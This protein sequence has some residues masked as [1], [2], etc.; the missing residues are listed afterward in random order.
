MVMEMLKCDIY[1]EREHHEVATAGQQRSNMRFDSLVKMADK[2]MLFKY[3]SRTS[4]AGTARPL[5]HAEAAFRRQRSGM[6]CHQSI[7]NKGK[8]LFAGNGYA[9]LRRAGALLHRRRAEACACPGCLYEPTTNSYKR[10]TPGFEAP[11][12]LAYSARNR[13]ASIRIPT[14]SQVRRRK[15]WRS[16]SLTLPATPISHSLQC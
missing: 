16:G 12:N 13:S 5:L 10:L 9:G 3:S 2:N 15:G 6:H 7:W 14:Y 1:V 4:H 8:P 11:V